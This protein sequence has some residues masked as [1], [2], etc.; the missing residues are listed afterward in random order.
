MRPSKDGLEKFYFTAQEADDLVGEMF[1]K[2]E[3][4]DLTAD[5]VRQAIHRSQT[6]SN[7]AGKKIHDFMHVAAAEKAKV[8]RIVT[9]NLRDFT[10]MTAIPLESENFAAQAGA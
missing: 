4:V 9:L 1:A 7:L 10:G 6:I 8:D 5:E 2:L 3:F